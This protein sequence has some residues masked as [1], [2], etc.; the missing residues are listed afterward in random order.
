MARAV[1]KRSAMEGSCGIG[2]PDL[3]NEKSHPITQMNICGAFTT[4]K[5]GTTPGDISKSLSCCMRRKT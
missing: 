5:H 3:Q 4:Q 1:K 2:I